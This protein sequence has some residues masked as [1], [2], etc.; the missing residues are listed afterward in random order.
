MQNEDINS[1]FEKMD[2]P[3]QFNK[4]QISIH[5]ASLALVAIV[6][7]IGFGHDLIESRATKHLVMDIH[8]L[9]GLTLALLVL[10]R[11]ALRVANRTPDHDTPLLLKLASQ[12]SQGAMYLLLVGLPVIGL[13]QTSAARAHP[14]LFGV[15]PLPVLTAHDRDLADSLGEWHERGAW[16]LIAL[17]GL[18][19]A[20]ALWHHYGRKDDVL[21]RMAP[22]IKTRRA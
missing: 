9:L 18:H 1:Q 4:T 17:I 7:A 22:W 13:M 3:L 16:V 14:T 6:I 11:L 15:I 21:T 10:A 5:W 19:A 12:A 20:A 2:Q 8:R